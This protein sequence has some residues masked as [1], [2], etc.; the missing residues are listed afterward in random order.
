MRNKLALGLILASLATIYAA[1]Q[2]VLL[3]PRSV[4][5]VV[6]QTMV[7]T[8]NYQGLT[9]FSSN[10][11]AVASVDDYGKVTAVSAGLTSIR[12]QYK[13]WKLNTNVT[14]VASSTAALTITC[15]AN[16]SVTTTGT[17]SV[18]TWADATTSAPA[19]ITYS[20]AKGSTFPIGTQVVT[21][22]A[23]ASGQT[24]K[25][26]FNVTVS[27][28]TNTS[29]GPSAS[30]TCPGGAIGVATGADLQAAVTAAAAGSSFCLAA[31]VH[32]V[33]SSVTPKTG[34][35]FT[36]AFGG[37]L[38]GTG[39]VTADSTQAAFRAH[40]QDI[41]N[42]TIS[43][44]VIRNMP[45]RGI[46]AY[47]QNSDGWTITHNEVTTA[48]T[49]IQIGNTSTVTF[50][51]I[52]HNSV[53]G[54]LAY[55]ANGALFDNNDISYNGGEQKL[56]GAN[57]GV[58]SNNWVH[59]NLG[60]GIW[61][62]T[63]NINSQI[64][65]NTVEDNTRHNIHYEISGNG[66]IHDNN[67]R[68]AGDTG[69]FVS[70][71]KDVDVYSNTLQDNFRGVQLYLNCSAVGGGTISWD[72]ANDD[73]YDNSVRVGTRS[74]S[75]A[76]ALGWKNECVTTPPAGFNLSL[77]TNGSKSLNFTHN[78]YIVP[79]LT[80]RWWYWGLGQSKTWAEWQA[81]GRD[82]TGSAVLP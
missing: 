40:N 78:S 46:H 42:V 18:V 28:I 52:H 9:H 61:F 6:G 76:N 23:T 25:C 50:N 80:T 55:R 15:P 26:S 48:K 66:L 75:W 60:D 7:I 82:T 38:D 77:Y 70:T 10:N 2:L 36:C 68:R 39:W 49:G 74:G 57:G 14:V 59:N 20:P 19:T 58:F 65:S 62:D 37:I 16:V 33:A 4:Q 21:A 17:S 8:T 13:Q 11:P 12:A 24:V 31:G 45:Q 64:F 69:V 56:V 44:C 73:V 67:V 41:D 29:K 3:T 5:L 34:D 51:W 35:T 72:L 81:L 27:Q 30:I 32:P 47:Y 54:Y 63:D 43:N 79:N 1:D 53:G 22:T 71:S